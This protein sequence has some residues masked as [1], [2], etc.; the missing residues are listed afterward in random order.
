MRFNI[1]HESRYISF[2]PFELI[3]PFDPLDA[4]HLSDN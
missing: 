1:L 3:D 2:L 4:L